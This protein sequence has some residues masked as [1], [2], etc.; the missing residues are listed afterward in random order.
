MSRL[1]RIALQIVLV[2]LLLGVV[3]GVADASTGVAEKVVLVGI[4]AL[5]VWAAVLVRRL[6]HRGP[7]LR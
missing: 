5:L 1:V 3:V 2:F 7:A 4:G 6:G